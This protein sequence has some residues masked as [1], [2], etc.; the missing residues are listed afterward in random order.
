MGS[1]FLTRAPN[2][3]VLP[4]LAAIF[5]SLSSRSPNEEVNWVTLFMLSSTV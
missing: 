4:V 2:V 5:I 3:I 1:S